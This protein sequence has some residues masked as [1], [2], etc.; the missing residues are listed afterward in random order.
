MTQIQAIKAEIE[1]RREKCADIAAD[2]SNEDVAEYYRGKE[3]AYDETLS[4]IESLEK[5]RIYTIEREVKLHP[6]VASNV[7]LTT[8]SIE[9]ELKPSEIAMLAMSKSVKLVIR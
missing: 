1:R 4:F 6:V 7:G 3:V 2:A 5:E 8:F 9:V